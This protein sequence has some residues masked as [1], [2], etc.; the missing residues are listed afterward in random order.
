[1]PATELI[2]RYT[3]LFHNGK[4]IARPLALFG[5]HQHQLH[6]VT[7]GAIQQRHGLLE[8]QFLRL[9]NDQRAVRRK[10]RLAAERGAR[11]HAAFIEMDALLQIL[12]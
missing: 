11:H 6:V 2:A 10:Q 12:L 7:H 3:G 5:I 1:V 9:V 4:R 8:R